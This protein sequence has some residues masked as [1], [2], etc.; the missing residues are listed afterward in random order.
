MCFLIK[1]RDSKTESIY[2]KWTP[3]TTFLSAYI[4]LLNI[5]RS[6]TGVENT[7]VFRCLRKKESCGVKSGLWG[8]YENAAHCRMRQLLNFCFKHWMTKLVVCESGSILLKLGPFY[9][10][11][12][13]FQFLNKNVFNISSY[14]IELT[15]RVRLFS[16]SEKIATMMQYCEMVHHTVTHLECNDSIIRQFGL[17]A[18]QLCLFCLFTHPFNSKCTSSLKR[19]L[20]LLVIEL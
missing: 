10:N 19:V 17:S 5:N 9:N 6:Q 16:F 20:C 12:T 18:D 15:L 7:F 14:H 1:I 4:R 13:S 2:F 8:G 3:C 11:L